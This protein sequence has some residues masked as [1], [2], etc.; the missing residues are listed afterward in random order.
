MWACCTLNH[1]LRPDAV[2]PARHGCLERGLPAQVSPRHPIKA[3]YY[4]VVQ[5]N[6]RVS[7]KHNVN[8]TK[9]VNNSISGRTNLQFF[10]KEQAINEGFN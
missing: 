4:E 3:Q 6:P 10:R 7:S 8:T 1:A 5:K 2:P 9:P